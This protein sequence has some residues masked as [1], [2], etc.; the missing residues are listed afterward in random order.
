MGA[1]AGFSAALRCLLSRRRLLGDIGGAGVSC[2]SVARAS[3][4]PVAVFWDLDNKP[5]KGIP[6]YE[7]AV[8]LKLAASRF[9]PV[10][11]AVA[12][13]DHHAFRRPPPPAGAPRGG[14]ASGAV[15]PAE[16]H[17]CGVCGRR[18]YNRVKLVNHFK[19]IHETENAKRLAQLDSAKGGRRVRLA[20]KLTV[21]MEK[22]RRAAREVL[23]PKMNLGD[24]G[25]L[26]EEL[27]RAGVSVRR[28]P[29]RAEAAER[30]AL[31]AHMLAAMEQRKALG[32]LMLVSDDSGLA[33]VLSE[34]RTRGLKTV[35]VGDEGGEGAL[36]RIADVGFTWREVASGK[37]GKEAATVIGRWKDRDLLSRLEWTYRPQKEEGEEEG[38]GGGGKREGDSLE[39]GD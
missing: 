36:K 29:D 35:V 37:A 38:G 32:C 7:A 3:L 34:A 20:A 25:G 14:E 19:Q 8:R 18:F 11:L 5:P 16:P 26:A 10:R 31:R 1:V 23:V 12:Y 27:R 33:G 9:G 13:A 4:P 39:T 15:V 24:G 21:K 30:G 2:C 28:M 22:F 6:P 17:L